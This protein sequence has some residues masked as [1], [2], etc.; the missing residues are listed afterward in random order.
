MGGEG[1]AGD[2]FDFDNGESAFAPSDSIV[3]K[4][5]AAIQGPD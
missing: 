4:A 3:S 1:L 2:L 5:L